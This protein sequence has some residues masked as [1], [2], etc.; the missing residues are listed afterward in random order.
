MRALR[1]GRREARRSSLARLEPCSGTRS[2]R[3]RSRE[4]ASRSSTTSRAAS[5][6]LPCRSRDDVRRVR[7]R[8]DRPGRLRR[9][10][11][12][13]R[14]LPLP[15][16]VDDAARDLDRAARLHP[17]RARRRV[18]ERANRASSAAASSARSASR[19]L[20]PAGTRPSIAVEPRPERR[21]ARSQLGAGEDGGSVRRGRADR[22][23]R[24]PGRG[25]AAALE[26][27]GTLLV[28]AAPRASCRSRPRRRL[29][30]GASVARGSALGA[31]HR[32][33]MRRS[34]S[35]RRSSFRRRSSCHSSAS[36]R[37]STS[38]VRRRGRR[39][40]SCR[41][42]RRSLDARVTCGSRTCR[43]RARAGDV[44]VQ[45][46]VA[47]TDGTDAE[48]VPTRPSRAARRE[49]PAPFGH[50][51]CGIARHGRSVSSP[52]TLRRA[53]ECAPCLQTRDAV[54]RALASPRRGRM[55]NGSRSC[56]SGSRP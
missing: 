6:P 24:R 10:P 23:G 36:A 44:L 43:A 13:T 47:L 28:F 34:P 4:S 49:S 2:S 7:G 16:D 1:L 20:L 40:S 50:E 3:R 9:A 39:S 55:R 38:I 46:E 42:G 30:Q 26:P 15:D 19:R 53:G 5:A 25:A 33:S 45:V 35:C 41:E 12:A 29:P 17:P 8:D 52:R 27:G 37:G 51:L 22:A 32:I 48:D 11:L 54:P 18:P 56:P 14:T 21:R 31:P